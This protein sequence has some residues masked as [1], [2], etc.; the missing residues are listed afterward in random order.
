MKIMGK[1]RVGFGY[2]RWSHVTVKVAPIDFQKRIREA[3]TIQQK[4]D[5]VRRQKYSRE[6]RVRGPLEISRSG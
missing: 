6:A 4:S 5:W 1:G 3:K 2:I